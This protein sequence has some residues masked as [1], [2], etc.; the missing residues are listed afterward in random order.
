MNN[1]LFVC[2]YESDFHL[3][4]YCGH[5]W[6]HHYE[7]DSDMGDVEFFDVHDNTICIIAN[8]NTVREVYNG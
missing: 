1:K 5:V 4:N 8:C 7:I 2:T 3:E 6:A